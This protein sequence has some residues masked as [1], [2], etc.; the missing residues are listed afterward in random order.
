[1]MVDIKS[2]RRTYIILIIVQINN[3]ETY[4]FNKVVI[5]PIFLD[6]KKSSNNITDNKIRLKMMKQRM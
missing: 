2:I 3:Y 1:M 6:F 4:N 5:L